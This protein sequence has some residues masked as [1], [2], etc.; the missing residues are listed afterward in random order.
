M[1]G[2]GPLVV[3]A[4]TSEPSSMVAATANTVRIRF[5]VGVFI[6]CVDLRSGVPVER[7]KAAYSYSTSVGDDLRGN[8]I[9]GATVSET[10]QLQIERDRAELWEARQRLGRDRCRVTDRPAVS[11][12]TLSRVPV[13]HES[14][15]TRKFPNLYYPIL[16]HAVWRPRTRTW[17]L[18]SSNY[19]KHFGCGCAAV[20][21]R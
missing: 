16:F 6:L 14:Q 12:K 11:S 7:R 2:C 4:M 10:C 5:L 17:P 15:G 19:L 20:P 18:A 21:L 13:P 3:W 1:V 9:T 8:S